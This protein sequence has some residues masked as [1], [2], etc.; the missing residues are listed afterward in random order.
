MLLI[1]GEVKN[2]KLANQLLKV[3]RRKKKMNQ[4][5]AALHKANI[6]AQARC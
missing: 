4:D 2:L 5:Q 1:L 3:R 6:A